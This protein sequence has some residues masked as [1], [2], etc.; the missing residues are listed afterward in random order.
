MTKL[1]ANPLRAAFQILIWILLHPSAWQV[2]IREHASHLT[3]DF[4]LTQ[5]SRSDLQIPELRRLLRLVYLVWPLLVGALVVIVLLLSG[6]QPTIVLQ[7]GLFGITLGFTVGLVAG[8]AASVAGGLASVVAVGISVGIGLGWFGLLLELPDRTV[9]IGG[10]SEESSA[11]T[12]GIAFVVLGMIG[13]VLATL[14]EKESSYTLFR[15]A[16]AILAGVLISAAVVGAAISTRD[17]ALQIG[18]LELYGQL[19]GLFGGVVLGIV[20]ALA[21]AVRTFR[22]PIALI[23]G[24]ILGGVVILLRLM[25]YGPLQPALTQA[26]A[27]SASLKLLYGLSGAIMGP[28]YGILFASLFVLPFVLVERIAGA[29][30]GALVGTLG[31]GSMFVIFSEVPDIS[32][33]VILLLGLLCIGI[34]LTYTLWLPV[35]LYPFEQLWNTF[36]YRLDKRRA[37][38]SAPFLT[39]H[40]VFWDE[41]QRLPLVSLDD[42]LVLAAERNTALG[43][44]NLNQAALDQVSQSHQRWAARTAQIELDAR[45]LARCDS[46]EAIVE[47][48]GKL[49]AGELSGPASSL[50][51][52]FSRVGDD[53][54]AAT[55]QE[56]VYNQ[57]LALSAIEDRL[58]GLLRELT[59]SNE[60]YASRFRPI[61]THWRQV[62]SRHIHDLAAAVELRQEIDSPYIIGVPLTAQQEIFVGRTEVS[63]RIEQLLL[64]RRHPPL[65]LYGQRRM[66]KTSLLNNLGR[67]L[68]STI[69]PM[70]VDLQGPASLAT[71]YTGFLYNLARGMTTSARRQR[72]LELPTITREYL[73]D[74]PF[75]AFD[76]WLD[77]VEDALAGRSALLAL[78]EFEALEE[79]IINERYDADAV[80]GTLRHIIQHKPLFKILLTGSHV[81]EEMQHWAGYLVNVQVVQ[82]GYLK[83]DETR[84]LIERPTPEFA[85]KY[86]P[87][88]VDRIVALTRGHPAL[89]QLL[90]YELVA[91]K[92]EGLPANRRLA[93]V[94][95]VEDAIPQALES[96]SF[97]F[98][99][100]ANQVGATGRELLIYMA[101]QADDI[102]AEEALDQHYQSL[103]DEPG[104][105]KSN[106]F[107]ETLAVLLRRDLIEETAPESDHFTAYRFQVE[108]FERWFAAQ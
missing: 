32:L 94:Q 27:G 26:V 55:A 39:N 91:L 33:S 52:S 13:S 89:T 90:C 82:I 71:D 103:G 48:T 51:R 1:H 3:P 24:L 35:L 76:E 96:G 46:V 36:L 4:T 72:E 83:D 67:L 31:S 20:F 106:A 11:L 92:N 102:V 16:G 17:V 60:K 68:P 28:L 108:L 88:A 98:T 64:D 5:L 66:G 97:F 107:E 77:A 29:R 38:T 53:L 23:A 101:K 70:F 61:A 12:G 14:R 49:A 79:A 50:L 57:R 54:K 18:N 40:S 42:Y 44:A 43:E 65:L 6:T 58:D 41:H 69:V 25:L 47:A 56:S 34:G 99:E 19:Y 37:P 81:I 80:L 73:E 8:S 86:E 78:D 22:L 45:M 30:A 7:A 105:A 10:G 59:R 62:T 100:M 85:L 9:A 87:D 95:D 75:T 84:Q 74:D 15:R 2:Y 104:S 21:V 63:S 93:T